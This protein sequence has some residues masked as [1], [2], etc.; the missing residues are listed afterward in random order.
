MFTFGII[1]AGGIANNFVQ[2]VSFIEDC[3]IGAV[4]DLN[5][6]RGREFANKYE[7]KEFYSD[8]NLMLQNGGLDAV[9]I[10]TTPSAHHALALACLSHQVAV[11]CEK[12]FF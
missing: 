4:C 11:I 5:E 2:A 6:E 12:A 1:G 9:Y 7:I 3:E 8:S 10:A